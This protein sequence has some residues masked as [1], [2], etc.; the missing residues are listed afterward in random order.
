MLVLVLHVSSLLL[1]LFHV[2][3]PKCSRV[4]IDGKEYHVD[5]TP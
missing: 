3:N 5:T 4:I 1:L 2:A